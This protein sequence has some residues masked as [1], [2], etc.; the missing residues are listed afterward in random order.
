MNKLKIKEG[1]INKLKEEIEILENVSE[2]DIQDI[3]SALN[4]INKTDIQ[5]LPISGETLI[6]HGFKKN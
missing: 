5:K 2:T 3:K 4:F 6:K 1:L